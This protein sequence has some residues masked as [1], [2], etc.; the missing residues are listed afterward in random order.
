MDG[1]GFLDRCPQKPASC[2]TNVQLPKFGE[3]LVPANCR[4]VST[5]NTDDSRE[6]LEPQQLKMFARVFHGK[7]LSKFPRFTTWCSESTSYVRVRCPIFVQNGPIREH[8]C[9]YCATHQAPT[10]QPTVRPRFGQDLRAVD[11]GTL[12]FPTSSRYTTSGWLPR[13]RK[14]LQVIAPLLER[15]HARPGQ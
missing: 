13:E 4:S 5:Q 9:N 10:N 11:W 7:R 15:S 2:A 3:T 6:L 1:D 8:L 12:L 14:V